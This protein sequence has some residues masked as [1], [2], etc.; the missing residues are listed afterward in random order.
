MIAPTRW[1]IALPTFDGSAFLEAT[2]R[3]VL[4]QTDTDFELLVCDDGSRDTTFEIVRQFCG[5]R[6]RIIGND[7]GRPFGLAGN[8]NRCVSEATGDWIT[9]LHQDDLLEPE[10]LANHRRIAE[11]QKTVGMI[12]GPVRLIDAEGS[13]VDTDAN[14]D[15]VWPDRFVVWPPGSLSR[16]LVKSNP[17]R[18]PGVSF[19]K[20]LHSQLSGFDGSWKYVLDW[21]FWHRAGQV[22]DVAVL[23]EC[24]ASQ[25]WHPASET[26][27]LARGT[28]DLEENARLMRSILAQEPF[29][30][31]ERP[32]IETQIRARMARAWTNRAYQAACRG[33]RSLEWRSIRAAWNESREV[34]A[35]ILSGSPRTLGRLV[36]GRRGKSDDQKTSGEE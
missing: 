22:A 6:A 2:L 26:Q 25:R 32:L 14:S 9:I 28:V 5:N 31:T 17:I 4:K 27:R 15:F 23:S 30:D 18:C 19:R 10:F 35:R 13:I 3:S 1:T 36:I 11:F 33:D 29:S 24:L 12:F 20:D 34:T 21:D 7:S 8:W 16:V